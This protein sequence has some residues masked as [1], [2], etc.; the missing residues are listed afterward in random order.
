MRCTLRMFQTTKFL[1]RKALPNLDTKNR[2]SPHLT[3]Y[4]ST[5]DVTI[6]HPH[7]PVCFYPQQYS[8]RV[9]ITRK[10]S[11]SYKILKP[12]QYK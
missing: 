5:H 8:A 7:N 4:I 9:E 3:F 2:I 12:L 6:I 1:H 10:V 11:N